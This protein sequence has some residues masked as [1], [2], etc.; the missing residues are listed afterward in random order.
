MSCQTTQPPHRSRASCRYA[1]RMVVKLTGA[2]NMS[3]MEPCD[4]SSS[5]IFLVIIV[6]DGGAI[7]GTESLGASV[8]YEGREVQMVDSNQSLWISTSSNGAIFPTLGLFGGVIWSISDER[9]SRKLYNFLE[10]QTREAAPRPAVIIDLIMVQF[11][12]I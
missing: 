12:S 3:T 8:R 6:S 10:Q 2:C 4:P 11:Q 5:S 9:H 1:T 7:C